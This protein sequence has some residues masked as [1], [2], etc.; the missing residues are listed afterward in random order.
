MYSDEA[1][2]SRTIE[3]IATYPTRT[4]KNGAAAEIAERVYAYPTYHVPKLGG[5]NSDY[6]E[7]ALQGYRDGSRSHPTMHAQAS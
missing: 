6:I 4:A 2:P 1:E 3:R 5:Q 7:I